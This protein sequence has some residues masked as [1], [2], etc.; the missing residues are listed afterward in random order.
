MGL[1]VAFGPKGRPGRIWGV[2]GGGVGG[3]VGCSP[4][5]GFRRACGISPAQLCG[6]PFAVISNDRH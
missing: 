1:V 2:G 4:C 6:L 5:P 3:E